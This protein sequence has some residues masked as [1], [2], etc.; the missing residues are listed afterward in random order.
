MIR[1]DVEDLRRLLSEVAG[2]AEK[3]PSTT[4]FAD[5]EFDALGY[6]SL[7]LMEAAARIADTYGV[8]IPDDHLLGARTPRE[9]VAFV[10]GAQAKSV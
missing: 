9:V 6:D 8:N 5:L 1:I 4:E 2:D 3:D 7:A 10:N